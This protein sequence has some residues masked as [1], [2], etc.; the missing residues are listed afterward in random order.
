[1]FKIGEARGKELYHERFRT[2]SAIVYLID[3]RYHHECIII[4]EEF[5]R[6][7]LSARFRDPG[8]EVF[9]KQ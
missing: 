4:P 5:K 2:M 6:K 7:H 3:A 1:M 9:C 8:G